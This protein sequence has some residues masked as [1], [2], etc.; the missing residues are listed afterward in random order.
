MSALLANSLVQALRGLRRRPGRAV[1]TVL[2][3]ALAC[4]GLAL[5]L[6]LVNAVL[7]RPLPYAQPEQ[8]H[9]LSWQVHPQHLTPIGLTARG[10]EFAR[11]QGDLFEAVGA[12]S[13]AGTRVAVGEGESMRALA[14]LRADA[15]LLPALGLEPLRGR[16]PGAEEWPAAGPQVLVSARIWRELLAA[17]EALQGLSLRVDGVPHAVVGVLPERFQ[18][19]PAVDVVLPLPLRGVGSEGHNVSMLARL[20]QAADTAALQALLDARIEPARESLGGSQHPEHPPRLRLIPLKQATVGDSAGLLGPVALAV[21]LLALLACFN[22]ANLQIAQRLAARGE[23]AVRVAL[24]ASRARLW[25]QQAMAAALPVL[26][27]LLLGVALAQLLLP[28]VLA[29]LPV[30]LPR[31]ST[32]TLD[33]HTVLAVAALGGLML[34][35][36]LLLSAFGEGGWQR[37]LGGSTRGSRRLGAQPLLVS[38]QVALSAVLLAGCLMALGSLQRILQVDP[39]YRVEGVQV[40]QLVLPEADFGDP[41]TAHEVTARSLGALRQALAQAPGVQ[42]VAASSSPPLLRGLNNYV[43]FPGAPRGIDGDSVELRLV[44]PGY[45]EALGA[46][47]L[48]GRG[49]HEGDREDSPRVGV[50]NARF[51][52]RYLA[53]GNAVGQRLRMDGHEI[54]VVGVMADL[55]ETSLRSPAEPT[56]VVP[57]RQADPGLQAAVNRWFGASLLVRADAGL[58]LQA[59]L[60]QALAQQPAAPVLQQLQPL[61]ALQSASVATE[62]FLGA[63]L[64]GF[65]LVALVLAA[66]GLYALLEHQRGL[67]ERELAVRQALGARAAQNAGLLVGQGLRLAAFGLTA[68]AAGAWLVARLM[69]GLLYGSPIE[70]AGAVGLA[71]LLVGGLAV[72]ASLPPARVA[73]RQSPAAALRGD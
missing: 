6:A 23:Q 18:F 52:E 69:S 38:A 2:V 71:L 41:T 51:A 70:L 8:L 61:T 20:P 67:R 22:L 34:L 29:Q 13:E 64:G 7:L 57:Q 35:I 60:R 27:G 4:A 21:G 32:A 56:L 73:W 59:L 19:E 1:P 58:P 3:T 14:S 68:G 55:R 53:P 66:V 44:G 62:R 39:G 47:L 17:S 63:I 28:L 16:W 11:A 43:E 15:G 54:E 26:L 50:V 9:L 37:A 36:S 45:L 24:G 10:V 12:W 25:L 42:A 30:A 46:R 40:A 72:L 65:A 33:L 5:V 49:I 48:H 31:A